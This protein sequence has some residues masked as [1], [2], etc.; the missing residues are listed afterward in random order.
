MSNLYL[1]QLH[2]INWLSLRTFWIVLA[3]AHNI[4]FLQMALNKQTTTRCQFFCLRQERPRD[5]S[6]MGYIEDEVL[7][8]FLPETKIERL[9][10]LSILSLFFF[11][12]MW[13]KPWP[14]KHF[15]NLVEPVHVLC[16]EAAGTW[17]IF[18]LSSHVP[19]HPLF[20]ALKLRAPSGQ[21]TLLYHGIDGCQRLPL[22]LGNIP[23]NEGLWWNV[24]NVGTISNLQ[25]ETTQRGVINTTFVC[26]THTLKPQSP[27]LYGPC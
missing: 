8:S 11:L 7:F 27:Q 9:P 6:V 3:G 10:S 15:V 4:W 18:L 16:L 13:Y 14:I 19:L 17:I 20:L 22:L 23:L 2:W 25:G 1:L 12:W 21:N 5:I 26:W 24:Y